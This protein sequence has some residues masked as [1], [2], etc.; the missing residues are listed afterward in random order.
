DSTIVFLVNRKPQKFTKKAA[1]YKI[2][3]NAKGNRGV[4]FL[5]VTDDA[6]AGRFKYVLFR[7]HNIAP[8]KSAHFHIFYGGV[9]QDSLFN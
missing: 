7:D 8:T 6:N 4:R 2:I 9:S 3:N 5:F 1:G